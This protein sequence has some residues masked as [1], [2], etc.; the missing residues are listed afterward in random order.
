MLQSLSHPNIVSIFDFFED[1]LN[2]FVV[3][4]FL[5]GGELFDRLIEKSVNTESEARNAAVMILRAVKHCH[6]N[7]IVHRDVK[8]EN[9]LLVSK[10]DDSDI[11]LT[12]F[13]LAVKLQPGSPPVFQVPPKKL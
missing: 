5:S 8:P 7:H 6:D 2:F 11:K 13:G 3:L 9:L 12:D 1:R 10:D 4:E